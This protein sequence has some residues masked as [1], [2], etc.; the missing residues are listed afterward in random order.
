[1]V[2]ISDATHLGGFALTRTVHVAAA[3]GLFPK[4]Q[5]GA[6]GT[7][8]KLAAGADPLDVK[9]PYQLQKQVTGKWRNV[10]KLMPSS[11][12]SR[13]GTAVFK[14]KPRTTGKHRNRVYRRATSGV[15]GD[16]SNTA[17][18]VVT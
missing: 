18:L 4:R 6:L 3:V 15:S 12:A 16:Y 5:K 13:K 10:A 11:K 17:T 14:V 1:M 8:F 7:T 9:V 2:A